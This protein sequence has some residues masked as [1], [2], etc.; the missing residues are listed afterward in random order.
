MILKSNNT[1][2]SHITILIFICLLQ[3]VLGSE[4]RAQYRSVKNMLISLKKLFCKMGCRLMHQM[5][6]LLTIAIA[7]FQFLLWEN[8]RWLSL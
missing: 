4:L 1:G 8:G 5:I 3:C 2:L 7:S 6:Y